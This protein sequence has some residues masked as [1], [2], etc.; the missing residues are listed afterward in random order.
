MKN[1]AINSVI[2][3]P[4]KLTIETIEVFPIVT[5]YTV[6]WHSHFSAQHFFAFLLIWALQKTRKTPVTNSFRRPSVSL[7]LAHTYVDEMN[8]RDV[9]KGNSYGSAGSEMKMF[10]Q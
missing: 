9:L 4:T 5:I 8:A 7:L 3:N 2:Y 10:E 1:I 6:I